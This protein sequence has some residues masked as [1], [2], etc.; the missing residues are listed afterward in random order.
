MEFSGSFGKAL[1]V[2]HTWRTE[3]VTPPRVNA[4]VLQLSTYSQIVRRDYKKNKNMNN[5]FTSHHR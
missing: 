1:T 3:I 4:V 5:Q 2:T